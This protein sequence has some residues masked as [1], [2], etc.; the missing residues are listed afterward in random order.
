MPSAHQ[1]HLP[2][3]PIC[4]DRRRRAKPRTPR[5]G[6][7]RSPDEERA[8]SPAPRASAGESKT[9]SGCS[10]SAAA[11]KTPHSSRHAACSAPPPSTPSS[12][13]AWGRIGPGNGVMGARTSHGDHGALRNSLKHRPLDYFHRTLP[14]RPRVAWAGRSSSP[15]SSS[16]RATSFSQVIR[17]SF[18]EEERCSFAGQFGR[19]TG[20]PL[21]SRSAPVSVTATW[22]GWSIGHSR[23]LRMSIFRG[24]PFPRAIRD[25]IRALRAACG[26]G[27]SPSAPPGSGTRTLRP[28]RPRGERDMI[29]YWGIAPGVS[30]PTA[31]GRPALRAARNGRANCLSLAAPTPL[32]SA[33]SDSV[34]GRRRA[35]SIRVRSGKIT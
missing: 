5:P 4:R 11:S 31:S 30:L 7:S 13:G 29:V 18:R 33:N 1:R 15:W 24:S 10:G 25:G 35:M 22:D 21:P 23:E 17:L 20:F 27:N 8:A 12:H 9:G 14:I 3:G 32:T 34:R 2:H 19:L 28:L 6:P 16:E 26:G